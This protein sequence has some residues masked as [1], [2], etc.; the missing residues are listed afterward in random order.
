[1]GKEVPNEKQDKKKAKI[2]FVCIV[3]AWLAYTLLS[4][5]TRHPINKGI[6]LYQAQMMSAS[7]EEVHEFEWVI[8]QGF[9]QV[10][11]EL[12]TT[13]SFKPCVV[14]KDA[15]YAKLY[16]VDTPTYN[17]LPFEIGKKK[18]VD[19]RNAMGGP[20][21]IK[22]IV[23]FS[24][25]RLENMIEGKKDAI[26]IQMLNSS[27]ISNTVALPY[28]VGKGKVDYGFLQHLNSAK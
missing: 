2:I 17:A 26:L 7:P 11:S 15:K 19:I 4:H 21:Q 22:V 6:K 10:N 8:N 13:G 23:G 14:V 12:G 5:D 24:P 16:F 28:V 18:L 9:P 1:M 20:S 25:G 3:L 27:D